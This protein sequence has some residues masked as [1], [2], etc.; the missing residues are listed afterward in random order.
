MKRCSNCGAEIEEILETDVV[1]CLQ[2]GGRFRLHDN[3][4]FCPCCGE[5]SFKANLSHLKKA[6]LKKEQWKASMPKEELHIKW[7]EVSAIGKEL[8]PS[9]GTI[10]DK[11]FKYCI[12]CGE[13]IEEAWD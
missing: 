12:Y 3:F 4:Y 1:M 13:D 10:Q 7:D 5:R 2:C 11:G 9:C 8:C 6:N